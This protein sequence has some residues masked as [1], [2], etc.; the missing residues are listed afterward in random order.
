[1]QAAIHHITPPKGSAASPG[2][3][4]Q[5]VFRQYDP[6]GDR[7]VV[8]APWVRQIRAMK[9]F[10]KMDSTDFQRHKDRVIEPLIERCTPVVAAHPDASD[11]V[12]GWVC[13]AM[14]GQDQV[15]HFI[16]VRGAFRRFGIGTALMKTQFPGLGTRPLYYTHRTA[17]MKHFADRWNA[18]WDPYRAS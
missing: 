5:V 7:G 17:A 3:V 13:G 12:F 6:K 8:L 1:M 4:V 16:Y 11:Q 18:R 10:D 15:L 2:E 9:P 14:D